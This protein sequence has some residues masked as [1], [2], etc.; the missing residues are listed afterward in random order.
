MVLGSQGGLSRRTPLI[1]IPDRNE[2]TTFL[3]VTFS[4]SPV[5]YAPLWKNVWQEIV[6]APLTHDGSGHL[7]CVLFRV[8]SLFYKTIRFACRQFETFVV[9][10]SAIKACVNH[11]LPMQSN[12][13]RES[14]WLIRSCDANFGEKREDLKFILSE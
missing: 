1:I 6:H 14:C 5:E 2:D 4:V 10:H 13:P 9:N 3:Y 12:L 8:F 7:F 11:L